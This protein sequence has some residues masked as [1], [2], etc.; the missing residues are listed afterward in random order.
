MKALPKYTAERLSRLGSNIYGYRESRL[1]WSALKASDRFWPNLTQLKLLPRILNKTEK[2]I[3]LALLILCSLTSLTVI[4][5]TWNRHTV[6]TPTTGGEYI[7]ALVGEI[8]TLNPLL[9]TN[10]A[11]HDISRLISRGL[12]INS[13]NGTIIPDLAA[14]AQISPDKKVYT[15]KL[16]NNLVW[17]DNYLMTVDDVIFTFQ[18]IKNPELKSPWFNTFK[19]IEVKKESADTVSFTLPEPYQ[20]FL[21]T[22]SVGLVPEHLWAPVKAN[23]WL[24]HANN[25][26]PIGLGP[27]QFKSILRDKSGTIQNI[28][29]ER[30]NKT[31]TA[32]S[33]LD[34]V[35]FKIYPDKNQAIDAIRQNQ[36]QGLSGL[37]YSD[38]FNLEDNGHVIAPIEM[39][40]Y[41]ALFFNFKSTSLVKQKNLRLA[42]YNALNKTELIEKFINRSVKPSYGPFVFG[43]MKKISQENNVKADPVQVTELV[44][45]L[46]YE[47]KSNNQFFT[48]KDNEPLSINLTIVNQSDYLDLANI[49]KQ[50]W[51]K[52][53]F[54]INLD[55]I[56]SGR[57]LDIIKN[58]QYELIIAT[59]AVGLDQD[60][61]PYWHSSQASG[62]G[63]N[64]ASWQNFEADRLIIEA[65]R[66]SDQIAKNNAYLSLLKLINQDRPA[67][68]LFSNTYQYLLPKNLKGWQFNIIS[69][70]TDRFNFIENWYLKTK[71]Q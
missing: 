20:N 60:P 18:S 47:K 36:A 45:T 12:F 7:E 1:Y 62:Q 42:L 48:N 40:Q 68:F 58:R 31:H 39:P 34:R 64:L 32:P 2:R 14:N 44:K 35:I 46:G 52:A 26:A 11:E 57:W 51:E 5:R 49:L 27:F 24:K 65:R 54:K 63:S 43:D 19:K 8:N 21:A 41:T 33:L 71:R 15:I 67:I 69:E 28:I 3:A 23:D 13:Y 66:N 16:K 50:Q 25:L 70:P 29:L 9:E 30:N 10:Q 17:S 59:E 61:Y 22:L 55:I 6:V 53:G 37:A 56:D 4:I 38:N